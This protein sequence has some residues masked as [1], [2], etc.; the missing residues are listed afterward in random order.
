MTEN[1]LTILK[2]SIITGDILKDFLKPSTVVIC[3]DDFTLSRL[4]S[5]LSGMDIFF[6]PG[7][8]TDTKKAQ[9]WIDIRNR[10]YDIIV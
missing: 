2:D 7:E 6:L 9:S 1:H 8:S 3:P 4:E 10:K 5:E